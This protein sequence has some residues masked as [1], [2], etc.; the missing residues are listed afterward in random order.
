MATTNLN[1]LK[2]RRAAATSAPTAPA[3][4]ARD[5]LLVLRELL[6]E[7]RDLLTSC[8]STAI[9]VQA[10]IQNALTIAGQSPGI[11]NTTPRSFLDAIVNAVGS[12]LGLSGGNGFLTFTKD[13]CNFVPGWK[14]LVDLVLRSGRGMV[15]TGVVRKGDDFDYQLG[16]KPYL[17]HRPGDADDHKSITYYYAIGKIQGQDAPLIEVWSVAKV[18]RHLNEH[19]S[20]G[21]S[22]YALKSDGAMEAYGRKVPLLRVLQYMPR[23]GDLDIALAADAAHYARAPLPE[24]TPAPLAETQPA[25][26]PPPAPKKAATKKPATKKPATRKPAAKKAPAK[27]AAATGDSTFG[28]E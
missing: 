10:E 26:A 11:L 20:Q 13:I 9:N 21:A 25:D 6:H 19:N 2:K 3:E 23:S 22:H 12:G 4:P 7:N 15:W 8:A 18:I 5:P 17:T 27:K 1:D 28:M 14:G 16:D 24:P